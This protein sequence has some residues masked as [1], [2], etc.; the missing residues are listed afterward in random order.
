MLFLLGCLITCKMHTTSTHAM[1][2]TV[3]LQKHAALVLI[4]PMCVNC[5]LVLIRFFFTFKFKTW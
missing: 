3:L 2:V 4:V 1:R 5:L